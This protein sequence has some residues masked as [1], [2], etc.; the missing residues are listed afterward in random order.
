MALVANDGRGPVPVHD[1]ERA[2]MN[3]RRDRRIA[4]RRRTTAILVAAVVLLT[5]AAA[6]AFALPA[7]AIAQKGDEVMAMVRA[8]RWEDATAAATRGCAWP[9]FT[10]PIPEV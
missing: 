5:L 9:V 4:R 1:H 3:Q 6:L 7:A 10:T 2:P 8:D